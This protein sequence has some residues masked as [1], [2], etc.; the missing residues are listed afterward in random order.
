MNLDDDDSD[1]GEPQNVAEQRKKLICVH[2]TALCLHSLLPVT[3]TVAFIYFI[4]QISM[5][6]Y[7]PYQVKNADEYL[8]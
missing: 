1:F 4:V 7:N 6:D 5:I 2:Y 8:H 3:K